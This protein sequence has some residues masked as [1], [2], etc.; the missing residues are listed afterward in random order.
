MLDGAEMVP[1]TLEEI[2]EHS[3]EY[4]EDITKYR[5][6]VRDFEG[7]KEDE[8]LE[9]QI[10]RKYYHAKQWDAA[11]L[12]KLK[13]RKQKPTFDNKIQR[14]ID[15][16][17]GVEQRTRRDPKASPRTPKHDVDA[18]N[19]TMGLRY[20]CDR[21]KWKKKASDSMHNG[22]TTG[23]GA[24]WIGIRRNGK[25]QN[26]VAMDLVDYDRFIYDPRSTKDDFSDA[27]FM[28]VHLW[29]DVEEAKAIAPHYAA[30][31]DDALENAKTG[32]GAGEFGSR[33]TEEDRADQWAD[34]ENRRIR[35]VELYEKWFNVLAGREEW[36]FCKFSGDVVI[37]ARP[38]PYLDEDGIPDNPYQAW[39]AYIDEKGI[40]Y[41]PI[42][43]MKPMQDEVNHRRARFLHLNDSQKIFSRDKGSVADMDD[44]KEQLHDPNGVVYTNG[45]KWGEDMGLIDQTKESRGQFELLMQA[46]RSLENTGP[47]PGLLGKGSG[48]DGASGRALMAQRDSGMTE[49]SPVFE[50]HREWK[51][52]CYKKMS[53]RMRQAWT[54]E[55][56]ITVT[57]D[58]KKVQHIGFN[59][60]DP[61]TGQT[62]NEVAQMD[63]D[64]ILDEGPDTVV[65]QEELMQTLSQLGSVPPNMWK[66]FIHLSDVRNKDYLISIIDEIQKPPPEMVEMQ[67]RMA[68]LEE[69]LQAAKI[70]ETVARR[71]HIESQT[72]GELAKA[73]L[74]PEALQAFPVEGGRPSLVT[75]TLMDA[76]KPPPGMAPPGAPPDAAGGPP[77]PGMSGMGIPP[78]PTG[79]NDM[80]GGGLPV[81]AHPGI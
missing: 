59:V 8:L 4:G 78:P 24:V 81:E 41:S 70:D 69:L 39:T 60:M 38:S 14:K 61:M 57:D 47:N 74:P 11:E 76:G 66:I 50:N 13:K 77:P 34:F 40:R 19:W 23:I 9:Q 26:D 62:T 32:K 21:N 52:A 75:Q 48:V 29:V 20:V 36:K 17:V 2:H 42:R 18:D 45:L 6:W 80:M 22:M 7:N 58:L 72:A 5:K 16:L 33:R 31:F 28:G 25:G 55:K 27:R 68:K 3:K 65:M 51:L 35:I 67:T 79:A 15:F 64:I 10:H 37:D 44:L 43:N 30:Y 56:W 71:D 46:E 54:G 73:G 63:V 53:D 12:R 49:L 1:L